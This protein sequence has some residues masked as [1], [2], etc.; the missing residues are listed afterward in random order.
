[1]FRIAVVDDNLEYAQFVKKKIH[2]IFYREKVVCDVEVF[3]K[4][5]AFLCEVLEEDAFDVC[6]LDIEMPSMNGLELGRQL[7]KFGN[8]I[9]IVYLTVHEEFVRTGYEV[10][11]LDYICKKDIKRDLPVVLRR[12]SEESVDDRKNVYL[13][14][15][16][17]RTERVL[18]EEIIYVF[19]RGQNV[20]FA[21]TRGEVMERNALQRVMYK[22]KGREFVQIERGYIVNL[23]HIVRIKA[24]EVYLTNGLSFRASKE[25]IDEVRER[26]QEYWGGSR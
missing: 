6:F 10:K 12:L 15:E 7:R 18:Y 14:T 21:L 20:V 9:I 8:R 17:L 2:E 22:L 13:I 4:P 5:M 16:R 1:M 19:R 23:N 3:D 11:A 25:R 24:R 26:M